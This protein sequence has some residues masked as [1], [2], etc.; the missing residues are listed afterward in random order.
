MM[1]V[2][3]NG[4]EIS[5]CI[6]LVCFV[7][8]NFDNKMCARHGKP[9]KYWNFINQ[10]SRLCLYYTVLEFQQKSWKIPEYEPFLCMPLVCA[11]KG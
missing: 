2:N 5:D 1:L 11:E 8:H 6:K 9:G 3:Y 4:F 7:K 10:N